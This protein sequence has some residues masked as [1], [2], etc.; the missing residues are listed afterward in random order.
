M[1]EVTIRTDN[2]AFEDEENGLTSK[3][4]EAREVGRILRELAAA[5]EAGGE[6]RRVLLFDAN[7]NQVG[8][9]GVGR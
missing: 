1:Y 7:G 6:L 5:L 9:A 2:A 8:V 4:A 3:D